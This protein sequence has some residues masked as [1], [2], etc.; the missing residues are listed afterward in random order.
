M[1]PG[2]A[3]QFERR[4]QALQRGAGRFGWKVGFGAPSAMQ[5]MAIDRPL[6]GYLTDE[7][8][9]PSG[10]AVDVSGWRQAVIEFEIA[11]YIG[12]DVEPG[13]DEEAAR[14]AVSA[15]GPAIELAD[16][17]LPIGPESIG[18]IVAGNIF[19]KAV[20]LGEPDT[21]RYA[22]DLDGLE[23]LV[24]VDGVEFG[25]TSRLED[26]T[27]SYP[28]VVSTVASTV[29][30][31]GEMLRAGDVIIAGSVFPPAA[32][33]AA[34]TYEFTLHPLPSIAVEVGTE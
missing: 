4:A 34:H 20:I 30:A 14:S 32:I 26:L 5:M 18:E 28:N 33:D 9:V 8:V 15:I 29:A 19:H 21:A 25:R 31:Q 2:L 13:A 7:G 22:I 3:S 6:L 17:D 27:G 12:S 23:A 11:L 16:V 1:V 24:R 10:T